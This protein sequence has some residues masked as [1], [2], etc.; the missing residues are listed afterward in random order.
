LLFGALKAAAAEPTLSQQARDP[1]AFAREILMEM[2]NYLADLERLGVTVRGGYDAV[3]ADGQKIEFL[4]N[5]QVTVSRPGQLRSD[6][7][8]EDGQKTM[9]LFDG[10]QVTVFDEAAQVYAQAPQPGSID[11]AFVYF[12]RDL[13]M[14]L[15]LGS[16]LLQ[17][18]PAELEQR[19][20]SVD[21]VEFVP[22]PMFAVDAQHIAVRTAV[23]DVQLWIADDLDTPW[24]L[25][26]VLTYPQLPGQPQYWAEFSDWTARPKL[27]KSHF[28]FNPPA[29]A[30]QIVFSVQVL[31][32]SQAVSLN[33]AEEKP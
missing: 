1:Q 7:T 25:R 5:M 27:S 12:T 31:P 9:V 28:Q 33:P 32:M 3:Q 8:R 19:A 2:A 20:V 29:D 11:D 4:E 26:M 17:R 23:A 13:G 21:Y 10:S 18:L 30:E 6:Q 15:P 14:Q 22:A 24:P 16:L